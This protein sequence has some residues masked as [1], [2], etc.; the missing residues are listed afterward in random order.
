MELRSPD[1]TM[2]PYLAFALIIAAG[3]E[4]MEKQLSLPPAVDVD[5]YNADESVT[6]NL[7]ELPKSLEQAIELAENSDLV[8][9]VVGEELL[10]KYIALKKEEAAAFAAA[11]DK[12][13]FYREKYFR[14]Y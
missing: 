14:L 6:A 7:T 4:G 3:L 5:L 13:V 12:T 8:K 9:A 10:A 11:E 1:P 2:N